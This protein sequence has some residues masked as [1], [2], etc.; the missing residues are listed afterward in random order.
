[1]EFTSDTIADY[2][3]ALSEDD[4]SAEA[5][6]AAKRLTLDSLGCCLG[7]YTSPP[8]K[9][10]RALYGSVGSTDGGSGDRAAATVFGAGTTTRP[11][12]A[13]LIN[14]TMV[15]YLD[16]NDAFV[17]EGRACHPSDHIPALVSVAEAEGATGEELLEAIVVAYEIEGAGLDTGATW[18]HGYDYVTW[19]AFS[20]VAA[21]G[22][23]MGLDRSELVNALGIAGASNLT[24]S[25]ARKGA[26]SMWKGVAHPYVSHNAV[27]ACQ[28]AREGMTG[29][30]RVF[31]GPG[32]FFE[33]AADRE[34]TVDELG[35]RDGAAYRI[36]RAHVKPFPCG[37]YMQPMITGVRDLVAE[38]DIGP[39]AI[40]AIEIETFEQA[41]T[42]LGGEEKWSTDLTR[43]SA[44]HSIP[45]TAALAVVHG[46]VTPEHY[47]RAY[48]TDPE[49]HRLMQLVSVTESEEMNAAARAEPN[50]TPSIVRIRTPDATRDRRVDYAPGHAENPLPRE[51]LVAKFRSMADPLLTEA[52]MDEVIAFCDDLPE[53]SDVGSLVEALQV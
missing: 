52:A 22:R 9:H 38:H 42:I 6:D 27:Q 13:A 37:Y 21:A 39:D 36:T 23:L 32:G 53:R 7:A 46:D 30:E 3:L 12:Y 1:M 40:E 24:L 29:P 19:G 48:R 34:L 8:S 41:A 5:V 14:G 26:V 20:T 43:E 51:E 49:L 10:L 17:S 28:L 47:G 4:L 31:E 16:Y 33:V 2:A 18:E 15:R 45:Y 35:G 11:E 50:S 25:V 44:D